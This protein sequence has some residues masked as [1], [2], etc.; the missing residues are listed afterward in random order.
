MQLRFPKAHSVEF[1]RVALIVQR[2]TAFTELR[3]LRKRVVVA[4]R[5][6]FIRNILLARAC[7]QLLNR[8]WDLNR[9][10]RYTKG[11]FPHALV[12]QFPTFIRVVVVRKRLTPVLPFLLIFS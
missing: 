10:E 12:K 5:G 7:V 3:K 6:G 9:N 1:R 8:P 11:G 4:S 2:A